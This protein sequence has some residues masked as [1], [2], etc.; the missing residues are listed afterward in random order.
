MIDN[1]SEVQERLKTYAVLP[2]KRFNVKSGLSES[3]EFEKQKIR[4]YWADK[5]IS[6]VK[7]LEG[8]DI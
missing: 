5:D 3:E 2:D 8:L 7:K 4:Q 1:L 6:A